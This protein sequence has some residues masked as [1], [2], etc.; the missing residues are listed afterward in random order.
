MIVGLGS[1]FWGTAIY[2]APQN[3]NMFD[4][5][6]VTPFFKLLPLIL[7]ILGLFTAFTLYNFQSKTLFNLK[8]SSTGQKIYNFLN[9]KW[10][11]DKLYNEQFCQFLFN[12][13]YETSYKVVDRGIFEI[14]GPHGITRVLF[15]LASTVSKIQTGYIYHYTFVFL[16]GLT[17]ILAFYQIQAFV[18]MFYSSI[19]ALYLLVLLV[20]FY[21]IYC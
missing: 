21:L 10:F 19:L 4:A 3:M 1:D 17:L 13:S 12:F 11:F 8:I 6:F 20:I 2:T 14:L 5:E 15:K 16:V 9:K 18:L 7:S